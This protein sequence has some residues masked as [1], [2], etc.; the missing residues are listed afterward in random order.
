MWRRRIGA[1]C[2]EPRPGGVGCGV[3]GGGEVDPT[4]IATPLCL[5]VHVS[6]FCHLLGSW[7]TILFKERN[8][9]PR[10]G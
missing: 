2:P 10:L 1:A 4:V 5:P 7:A 6:R 9:G 8:P 3:W